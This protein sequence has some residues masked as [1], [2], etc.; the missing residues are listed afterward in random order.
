MAYLKDHVRATSPMMHFL[1]YA[2]NYHRVFSETRFYQ[3]DHSR[4]AYLDGL[5]QGLRRR[6]THAML[7]TSPNT[8]SRSWPY[9]S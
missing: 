5:Y 6:D 3:R 8:A 1:T 7:H 2:D 4:Q 9:A